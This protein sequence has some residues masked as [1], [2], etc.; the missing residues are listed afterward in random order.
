MKIS[1]EACKRSISIIELFVNAAL[2]AYKKLHYSEIKSVLSADKNQFEDE[3]SQEED[4]DLKNELVYK[5]VMPKR[6]NSDT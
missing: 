5:H 2:K 4:E 6:R 1:Y 3:E